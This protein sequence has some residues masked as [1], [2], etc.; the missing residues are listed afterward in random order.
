MRINPANEKRRKGQTENFALLGSCLLSLRVS[1]LPGAPCLS[2]K[3]RFI[4]IHV[5][6]STITCF[7]RRESLAVK[8]HLTGTLIH[9]SFDESCLSL[10][11]LP[12]SPR[13]P[14]PPPQSQCRDTGTHIASQLALVQSGVLTLARWI[15]LCD[16]EKPTCS[17]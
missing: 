10:A 5:K 6:Y 17:N 2:T 16:G 8:L 3:H 7:P 13:T 14:P 4:S 11:V 15:S 9:L 1:T 12:H